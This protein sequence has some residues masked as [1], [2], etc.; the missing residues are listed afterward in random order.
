MSS[1]DDWLSVGNKQ[2]VPSTWQKRMR[3]VMLESLY[4]HLL[5]LPV[6]TALVTVDVQGVSD[7]EAFSNCISQALDAYMTQNL[8]LSWP[9]DVLVNRKAFP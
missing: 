6:G 2:R 1:Q 7:P 5:A 9:R 3:N 8:R 4:T